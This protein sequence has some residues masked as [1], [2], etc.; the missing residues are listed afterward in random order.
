M[1]GSLTQ[2]GD[3]SFYPGQQVGEGATGLVYKG[4]SVMMI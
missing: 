3:F 4:I 2:I 1:Q